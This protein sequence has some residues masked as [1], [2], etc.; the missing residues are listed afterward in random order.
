MEHLS[1]RFAS[2]VWLFLVSATLLTGWL[3]E[4]KDVAVTWA[5]IVVMVI[6]ALKARALV[7]YY[8]EMHRGPLLW[9]LAFE[10]WVVFCAFVI[11]GFWAYSSGN[12]VI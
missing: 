6:A 2:G 11:A 9:R 10:F 8:M 3:V 7:L 4:Q 1:S 12:L 5:V